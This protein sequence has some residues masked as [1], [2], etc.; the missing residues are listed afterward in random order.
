MTTHALP[1]RAQLSRTS[2]RA[3]AR[4][5]PTVARVLLGAIFFVFGLNYFLNFIPPPSAPVPAAAMAFGG[6]L[7]QTGYMMPLIKGTEVVCGAL[8]LAKRFVPLALV[9]L[10]PV[11][12]N[13]VAF[14]A[15]LAPA[16]IGM[17]LVVLALELYLAW[18]ERAAYAPLLRA[19]NPID[20]TR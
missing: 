4:H 12:V 3:I 9:V 18:T 8:L 15:L 1:N 14:H 6:A 13:I 20:A 5:L 2:T 7:M 11:V 10:A 16:A 17:A 19:R